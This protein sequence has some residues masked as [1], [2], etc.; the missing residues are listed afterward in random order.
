MRF[1]N[2]RTWLLFAENPESAELFA[3]GETDS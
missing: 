2:S 1:G 3:L